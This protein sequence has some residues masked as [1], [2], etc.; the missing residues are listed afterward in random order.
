ME[1]ITLDSNLT[2]ITAVESFVE[3][4]SD[5]YHLNE[6]YFGPMLIVLTEAFKNAVIHGNKNDAKKK[7]YITIDP[8][9]NG[10][11][12]AVSDEG[13]GFDFD[14]LPDPISVTDGEYEN[15]GKGL[16]LMKSLT[17][18]LNF[19]DD[20]RTVEMTFNID[21]I[22]QSVMKD[23]YKVFNKYFQKNKHKV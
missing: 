20:G 17:N 22:G 12:F 5:R 9:Q 8:V 18:D 6:T 16:F 21:G 14:S 13:D 11:S 2:N 10:L 1:K 4:I 15:T 19:S 3:D 7:V 23:R